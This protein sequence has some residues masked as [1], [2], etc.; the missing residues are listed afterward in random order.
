M[1]PRAKQ[2]QQVAT[3]SLLILLAAGCILVISPFVAPLIWALVLTISTWTAFEWVKRSVGDRATLA[4]TI[5][6]L[7]ISL[8]LLVPL[9][10]VGFKLADNAATLGRL[11]SGLVERGPPPPPAWVAEIPLVGSDLREQWEV[12]SGDAQAF[13]D[14]LKP[15]VR[16]ATNWLVASAGKLGLGLLDLALSVIVAFFFYRY[17]RQILDRFH[18]VSELLAGP[19]AGALIKVAG[20]TM[21]GVVHGIL[22]TSLAQGILAGVGFLISGVP[23]AALLGLVTFFTSIFPFGAPLIWVPAA[24]WLFSQDQ[25]GWAIFL[26]VWGAF[27]VGSVDN[28]L[29]PILISQASALPLLLVFLGII[30]GALAFG[31][32]GIFLGPILLALAYTLIKSWTDAP[33]VLAADG[34]AGGGEDGRPS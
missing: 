6:M 21:R 1:P 8:F 16:R 12:M 29:K 23:G 27:V 11:V 15:Y 24:L 5:M 20:D 25:T 18:A 13:L 4:A 22:G 30:G 19:G 14:A 26:A 17:G 7:A 3:I 32:L 2:I 9:V 33:S 28:F 10:F 34:E 31:F